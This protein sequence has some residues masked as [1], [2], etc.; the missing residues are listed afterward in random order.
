MFKIYK[1]LYNPSNLTG[2]V[3]GNI[4]SSELSG[5]L[6][7]LFYHVSAPPSGL[8]DVFNQY[9]KVFFKNTYDRTA[10]EVRVWI[11]AAEH[12]DQLS[13]A[14]STGLSDTLI[15]ATGTS[16]LTGWRSP[17]TY[18][19]GVILGTLPVNAY[20]GVWIRQSLSGISSPDP[21]STFRIYVGGIV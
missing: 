11:D 21:Y 3:G 7:E 13:I 12:L 19:D 15:T 17:T 4:S 14:N 20:T 16:E 9:R 8:D 2:Q 18:T 5:Y 10:T 1:S 6:G